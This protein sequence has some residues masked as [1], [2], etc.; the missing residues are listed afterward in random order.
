MYRLRIRANA[1][2]SINN[3]ANTLS[4][5]ILEKKETEVGQYSG[6]IHNHKRLLFRSTLYTGKQRSRNS[7]VRRRLSCVIELVTEKSGATNGTLE[8]NAYKFSDARRSIAIDIQMV[9]EL[10]SATESWFQRVERRVRHSF[11]K[12][13]EMTFSILFRR[14]INPPRETRIPVR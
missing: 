11:E 5:M 1:R 3:S 6:A 12:N 13:K 7:K 2:E 10:V 9:T 14:C 4:L 8:I